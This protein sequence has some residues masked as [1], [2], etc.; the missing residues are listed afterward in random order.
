VVELIDKEVLEKMYYDT[1]DE[2]DILSTHSS[3]EQYTINDI[4]VHDIDV[5]NVSCVVHGE[6]ELRLQYGSDGD[7]RRG[8]GH[9][10]YHSF[11][12]SSTIIAQIN[13][14]LGEFEIDTDSFEVDTDSFY[15][16]DEDGYIDE[17]IAEFN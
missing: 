12:F 13:E 3:V 7:L 5:N 15:G 9:V 2:I 10:M 14:Q 4:N 17:A 1:I 8:D 6:V 11:P 16:I